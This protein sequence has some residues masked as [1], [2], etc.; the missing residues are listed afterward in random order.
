MSKISSL[1]DIWNK[2]K[3]E[4]EEEEEETGKENV[5]QEQEKEE[6]NRCVETQ[7]LPS[8][9]CPSRLW[10][11]SLYDHI[12]PLPLYLH[13]LTPLFL[14]FAQDQGPSWSTQAELSV[15]PDGLAQALPRASPV[16]GRFLPALTPWN[17]PLRLQIELKDEAPP[18]TLHDFLPHP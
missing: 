4:E 11:A 5:D 13:S 17:L 7:R 15:G 14:P 2:I 1:E 10:R 16:V 12:G 6:Q 9:S 3:L 8:S 18:P